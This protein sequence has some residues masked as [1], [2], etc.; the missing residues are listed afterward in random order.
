MA[1]VSLLCGIVCAVLTLVMLHLSVMRK[2]HLHIWP[3]NVLCRFHIGTWAHTR[4]M[5]GHKN[6][7]IVIGVNCLQLILS[8]VQWAR[9]SFLWM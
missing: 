5:W 3:E 1:Y 2:I 7:G 8:L 6:V 9:R 4:L